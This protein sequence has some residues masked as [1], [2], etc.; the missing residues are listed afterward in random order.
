MT[1]SVNISKRYA[2][3]SAFSFT[4]SGS[5]SP[6]ENGKLQLQPN[7]FSL[8]KR[9]GNARYFTWQRDGTSYSE[10]DSQRESILSQYD[11]YRFDHTS[12]SYVNNLVI[13]LRNKIRDGE[14]FNLAVTFAERRE[15]IGM[16]TDAAKKLN[17]AADQV[18]K[19]K[20]AAACRTLGVPFRSP[21]VKRG[22]SSIRQSA[23]DYWLAIQYGWIPTISDMAGAMIAADKI[24]HRE[25]TYIC[26]VRDGFET[27]RVNKHSEVWIPFNG[28]YH[29]WPMNFTVTNDLHVKLRL[30]AWFKITN[31]IL[32]TADQL[33]LLNPGLVAWERVPF[34]FVVDWFIPIGD[35]IAQVP[36]L[37]GVEV[38]HC[39]LTVVEDRYSKLPG[40]Y[41]RNYGTKTDFWTKD[42]EVSH[43]RCQRF[44]MDLNAILYPT[45][46]AGISAKRATSALALLS[47]TFDRI[48]KKR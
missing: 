27:S 41:T 39:F 1:K 8:V 48:A 36:P 37:H 43:Y 19:N 22:K 26:T 31:P 30:E 13:E 4:K 46:D 38:T 14:D 16:I 47:Q 25:P 45:W 33:G 3:G 24:R 34:S 32:K 9:K 17:K 6:R 23:S 11:N 29:I 40:F 12:S 20:H 44:R 21:Y 5:N 28:P 7:E 2:D 35:W 42:L 15:T 10:Y 18:S